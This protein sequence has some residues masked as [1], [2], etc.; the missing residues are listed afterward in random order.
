MSGNQKMATDLRNRRKQLAASRSDAEF[1]KKHGTNLVDHL[2]LAL[3]LSLSLDDFKADAAVVDGLI[4]PKNLQDAPGLVL[5]YQ[6]KPTAATLL[7]SVE[8]VLPSLSGKVGFHGKEY[9]GLAPASGVR[10]SRLLAAAESAEDSA[11][12]LVDQPAGAMLVD[13]YPAPGGGPFS[14][15]VQGADL[16]G[17][18]KA[19]FDA[20]WRPA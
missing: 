14:V 2:N 17:V 12:L 13:Y 18:L 5:A 20:P 3:G 19:C 8:R 16:V 10:A 11:L 6:E 7:N 4:W 9:L 1:R 15:V